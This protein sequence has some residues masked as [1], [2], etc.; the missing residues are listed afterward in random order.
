[1]SSASQGPGWWQAS[2]GNWYPPQQ[3]TG[4]ATPPPP[5]TSGPPG[6]HPAEQPAA[7]PGP[8]SWP[9]PAPGGYPQYPAPG[10]QGFGNAQAAFTANISKIPTAGWLLF[11]GFVAAILSLF[12][13]F[14]TVSVGGFSAS[15]S[16][17]QTGEG[18]NWFLLLLLVGGAGLSVRTSN[19]P[20]THRPTL[21]TLSVLIGLLTIWWIYQ[22]VT[23]SSQIK[24]VT[25]QGDLSGMD[26][27]WSPA[28]GF[29]LFTAAVGWLAVLIVRHWIALSKSQR[30]AY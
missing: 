28:I 3:Q 19:L 24:Q 6:Y 30:R 18:F 1:M 26:V 25:S 9:A 7:P 15:P 8:Q 21:I 12:L 10:G 14:L 2:D 20:H 16:V 23:A 17:W 22:L 5:A 4:Y 29:V 11:G 13:Q 27:H